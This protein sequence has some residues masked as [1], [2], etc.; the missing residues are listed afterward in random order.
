[1]RAAKPLSISIRRQTVILTVLLMAGATFTVTPVRADQVNWGLPDNWVD[2]S[3]YEAGVHASAQTRA[4]TGDDASISSATEPADAAE[5]AAAP[6]PP[7]TPA[8]A[9]QTPI[10][11]QEVASVTPA[12]TMQPVPQMVEVQTVPQT[13][14]A[15]TVEAVAVKASPTADN[16]DEAS[17]TP[18]S[19]SQHA[20]TLNLKPADKSPSAKTPMVK[21]ADDQYV[22]DDGTRIDPHH[23]TPMQMTPVDSGSIT[24]EM[25]RIW[26]ENLQQLEKENQ[27][28]RAKLGMKDTDPLSDIKV[29]V[30]EKIREEVLRARV[31]ELEKE[32]DKLHMDHNPEGLPEKSG[33]LKGDSAKPETA[34]AKQP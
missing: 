28:L 5:A 20:S 33:S 12:A 24:P 10:V 11:A 1:M 6:T 9:S 16:A 27:V 22:F 4:A 14:A 17:A 21:N 15:N 26:A 23:A 34:G 30:V 19:S 29:D 31:I 7:S 13:V 18:P 2:K 8:I 3:P 25:A 32:L